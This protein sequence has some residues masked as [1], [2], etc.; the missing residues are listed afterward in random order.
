MHTAGSNVF[1]HEHSPY[2]RMFFIV[3]CNIHRRSFLSFQGLD[4]SPCSRMIWIPKT[5]LILFRRLQWW[6]AVT[7]F[8]FEGSQQGCPVLSSI[9]LSAFHSWEDQA[10]SSSHFEL[11]AEFELSINCLWQ[12]TTGCPVLS[13]S[14]LSHSSDSDFHSFSSPR[15][16]TPK[17]T[18]SREPLQ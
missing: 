5:I 1:R 10:L 11:R 15:F 6:I 18:D 12:S 13:S 16:L 7:L 2:H 8:L 14:Q 3:F 9:D 17:M 4:H